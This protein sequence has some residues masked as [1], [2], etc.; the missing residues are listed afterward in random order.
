MLV[1][2][3]HAET[4]RKNAEIKMIIDSDIKL[5]PGATKFALRPNK[6]FIFDGETEER[7][8]LQ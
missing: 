8:Y 1:V 3:S 2:C 5:S 4:E 6:V 7:I